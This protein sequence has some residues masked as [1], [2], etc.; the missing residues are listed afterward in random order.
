MATA[1]RYT[2]SSWIFE[3]SPNIGG[4]CMV[5]RKRG[6]T[7]RIRVNQE[8]WDL[9]D[10]AGKLVLDREILVAGARLILDRVRPSE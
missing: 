4:G 2:E 5:K 9:V 7:K 8:E 10:E 3:T 1:S 6:L